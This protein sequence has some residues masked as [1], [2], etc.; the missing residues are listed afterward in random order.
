MAGLILRFKMW[1]D[2]SDIDTGTTTNVTDAIIRIDEDV[3]RCRIKFSFRSRD[4][5]H[6]VRFICS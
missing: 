6:R 1:T 3:P 5:G 2:A 4:T